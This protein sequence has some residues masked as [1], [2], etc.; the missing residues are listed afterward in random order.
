M[1]LDE[2]QNRKIIQYDTA[3]RDEAHAKPQA[4]MPDYFL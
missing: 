1:Q 4:R 2:H 3:V